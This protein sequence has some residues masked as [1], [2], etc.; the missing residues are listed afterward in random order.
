[1]YREMLTRLA[2]RGA[3]VVYKYTIGA[4]LV[5]VDLCVRKDTNLVILKTTHDERMKAYSPATLMRAESLPVMFDK[6]GIRQ[7]EFYGKRMD[8]H[9]RWTNDFRTMYHVNCDRWSVLAKLRLARSR[10]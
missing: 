1:M 6:D 3:A 9:T 2:R 4:D 5:A 10:P 7:V 8:W